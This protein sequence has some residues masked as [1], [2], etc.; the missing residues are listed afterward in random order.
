MVYASSIEVETN[1]ASLTNSE[2]ERI[3]LAAEQGTQLMA[4]NSIWPVV[5][6][7]V[8]R[9]DDKFVQADQRSYQAIQEATRG[10]AQ[11]SFGIPKLFKKTA[12]GLPKPFRFDVLA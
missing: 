6:E 3:I 8:G 12:E 2:E 4:E 11:K 9:S 5:L 7:K 10:E 1:V